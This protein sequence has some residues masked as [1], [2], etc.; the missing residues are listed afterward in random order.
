[1]LD[2][3]RVT[4]IN[5][6]PYPID[7]YRKFVTYKFLYLLFKIFKNLSIIPLASK[8]QRE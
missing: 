8:N 7:G 4:N 1:M 2:L 3:Q 6:Y 5:K